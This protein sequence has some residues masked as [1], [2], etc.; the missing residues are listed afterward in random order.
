WFQSHGQSLKSIY[1]VDV[2]LKD[3]KQFEIFNTFYAAF[4]GEISPS[5]CCIET[6][7]PMGVACRLLLTLRFG[8]NFLL[9]DPS[10][11]TTLHV[12]SIS[13]WAAACIGPYS[14]AKDVE[15]CI[16]ISGII[17]LIPHSM[18]F[19]EE[20]LLHRIFTVKNTST[21]SADVSR[22]I[23]LLLAVRSLQNIMKEMHSCLHRIPFLVVYVARAPHETFLN[24]TLLE[25]MINFVWD[26]LP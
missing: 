23:Q 2:Y 1:H 25:S 17:G 21:S 3:L 6:Q 18:L 16:S 15:G 19:P 12:Q 26:R 9:T 13:T 8:Y 4:F 14:Q 7:L 20:T 24:T 5:R 10:F 11:K 22:A